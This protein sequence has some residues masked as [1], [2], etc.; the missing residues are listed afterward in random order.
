MSAVIIALLVIAGFILLVIEIFFVPGFSIPGLAGLAM[1]GYGVFKA[2]MAY[3]TS[4]AL[5]TVASSALAAFILIKMALKSRTVRSIGLD[6]NE[7]QA[8]A[9]NDYSSLSGKKGIALSTL[10]PT[11]TAIIDG[12]R[13][14]VVSD[15]EFIEKD[16]PILVIAV[17]GSRIVVSQIKNMGND[18]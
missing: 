17:D 14:D 15:G 12:Q 4:G 2:K 1:I 8:K 13:I 6:Y 9:G 18:A 3:G 10:R 5:I 11:G 16:S 7:K